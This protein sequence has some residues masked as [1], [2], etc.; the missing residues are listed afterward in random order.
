MGGE[1][2]EE[3]IPRAARQV[4]TP[5]AHAEQGVAR[6]GYVLLCTIEGDAARGMSWGVEHTELMIAEG[7][8]VLII[9]N[10]A[11]R[12]AGRH[13]ADVEPH[14]AALCVYVLNPRRIGSVG[15]WFQAVGR[16]DETGTKHM[17][18]MSVG[19]EVVYGLQ[20]IVAD[21]CLDGSKL[22]VVEGAAVDDDAIAGLVAHYVAVLLNGIDG[23]GLDV[24][25]F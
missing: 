10:G 8:R 5:H 7:N 16:I 2:V 9:E 20:L 19:A 18:E 23:E 15:L 13:G 11:Y 14:H 24:E 21:V 1:T 12:S 3:L 4:G 25:H 17:I 6:E 22:A